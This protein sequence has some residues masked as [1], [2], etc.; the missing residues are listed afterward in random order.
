MI[1]IALAA[2]KGTGKSPLATTLAVQHNFVRLSF[3][4]PIR[5]MLAA[6]GINCATMSAKEKEEVIGWLGKSARQLLQSLGTKWGREEV[7]DDIWIKI[8][9]RSLDVAR[10]TGR[11]VVIDDLRFP[12]E[13]VC[14]KANGGTIYSLQRPDIM[15]QLTDAHISETGI[16]NIPWDRQITLAREDDMRRL[17]L[18]LGDVADRMVCECQP[19]RS[20]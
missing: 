4:E 9:Q 10:A 17:A 19:T 15:N 1:L 7:C 6:I 12:N 16:D 11:N 5:A 18:L 20:L 14:V 2:R 3:A 8:M 13:V